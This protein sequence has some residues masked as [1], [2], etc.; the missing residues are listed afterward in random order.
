VVDL[1]EEKAKDTI[2][3]LKSGE[4]LV[5]ENVRAHDAETEEGTPEEQTKKEPVGN[6]VA[7]KT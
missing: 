2:K 7:L 4:A 1:F 3:E 6:S 5:L